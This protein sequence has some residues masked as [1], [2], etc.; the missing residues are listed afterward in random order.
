MTRSINRLAGWGVFLVF[1]A[2]AAPAAAET[3]RNHMDRESSPYL[4]LH[5]ADPVH[6]RAW[7]PDTLARAEAAILATGKAMGGIC[8]PDDS[9]RAMLARGYKLLIANSD[10]TLLRDAARAEVAALNSLRGV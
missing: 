2:V 4:Q 10:A 6:W 3:A 1:L 8:R 9:A 7:T 5:A